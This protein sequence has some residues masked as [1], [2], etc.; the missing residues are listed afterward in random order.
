MGKSVVTA[1]SR[2]EEP[3]SGLIKDP[4]L[5]SSPMPQAMAGGISVT[6][7]VIGH[8]NEHFTLVPTLVSTAERQ[9]V[10]L[11]SS[12][13]RSVLQLTGQSFGSNRSDA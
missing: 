8:W 3:N 2:N 10:D 12:L 1:D 9:R 11:D 4:C 13:W 7:V 5:P 6:D